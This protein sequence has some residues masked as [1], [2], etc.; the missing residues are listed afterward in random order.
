MTLL[1]GLLLALCAAACFDAAIALQAAEARKV[2]QDEGLQASLLWRLAKRPRWLAALAL[3]G[4]GWPFQLAALS[5]VSLSVVQPALALGLVLLLAMGSR[6]LGERAG[7]PEIAG[8]LLLAGGVAIL[9]IG[10]PAHTNQHAATG[11]LIAVS[12]GLGVVALTPYV[13]GAHGS[14]LIASAGAAYTLAAITSKLLT[15]ELAAGTAAGAVAW[16]LVTAVAGLVG[17]LAETAALQ[18]LAAAAVAAPIFAAEAVVPVLAAPWLADEHWSAAVPVG[19]VLV[20]AG[21]MLLGRSRAVLGL[22]R[23]VA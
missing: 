21:T 23:E 20:L 19:L 18:R 7:P 12:A 14:A 17:K 22:I 4:L 3:D 11:A 2:T 8:V 13:L 15:D 9:A 5:L 10:A 16:A 1:A 6:V